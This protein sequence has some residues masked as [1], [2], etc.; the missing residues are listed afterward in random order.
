LDRP[1]ASIYTTMG[2]IHRKLADCILRKLAEGSAG[3][4][5]NA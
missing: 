3:G 5:E 1:V 2:R 4:V